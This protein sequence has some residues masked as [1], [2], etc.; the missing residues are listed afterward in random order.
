MMPRTIEL[1][2]THNTNTQICNEK[3]DQERIKTHKINGMQ[4][5]R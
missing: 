1:L 3:Y 2:T 4:Y 5:G